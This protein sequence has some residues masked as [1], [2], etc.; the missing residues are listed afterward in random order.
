MDVAWIPRIKTAS[1]L[2]VYL[3]LCAHAK[4]TTNK[5][6]PGRGR[7]ASMA[8]IDIRSVI[9]ALQALKTIG[10][11]EVRPRGPRTPEYTILP[12]HSAADHEHLV[13]ES[14]DA[15]LSPIN[16]D[17]DRFARWFFAEGQRLRLIGKHE[18]LDKWVKNEARFATNL[19]A[20]GFDEC[21]ARARRFLDSIQ[22]GE[23]NRISPTV[24]GLETA[25]TFNCVHRDTKGSGGPM[26][27]AP[28]DRR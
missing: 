5:C 26:D 6:T 3:V 20:N 8:N 7:I 14:D 15:T 11:I 1:D 19:L 27:I 10:A 24:H 12:A 13:P 4:A 16:D 23:L 28:E 2:K 25:W 18:T 22:S 21:Q 17:A 9:R